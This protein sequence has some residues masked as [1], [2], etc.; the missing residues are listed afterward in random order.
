MFRRKTS[1]N[2]MA[3]YCTFNCLPL[4]TTSVQSITVE[5]IESTKATVVCHFLPQTTSDGCLVRWSEISKL[6]ENS[7][8]NFQV[9]I[10]RASN[11]SATA[12]GDIAVLKPNTVYRVEVFSMQGDEKLHEFGIPLTGDLRLSTLDTMGK[13]KIS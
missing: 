8:D 12:S 5:S 6:A 4:V 3:Y 7:S 10:S 13:K 2:I 11:S 9:K 1:L